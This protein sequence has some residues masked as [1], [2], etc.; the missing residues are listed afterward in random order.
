MLNQLILNDKSSNYLITSTDVNNRYSLVIER[1][2]SEMN[3]TKK[4]IENNPDIKHISL[5]LIDK[6]GKIISSI[7]NEDLLLNNYGL[8]DKSKIYKIG[9][10]IS[11]NQIR[12]VISFTQIS[13]HKNKKLVIINDASRMNMEASSALLKTL[14]EVSS[15]CSFILIC[16]SHK[17]VHETIRSRCQLIK[18]DSYH[19]NKFNNFNEFFFSRH[20]FLKENDQYYDI[21]SLLVN[22]VD[23][24]NGLLDKSH[25]PIDVSA[26][27]YKS[28]I[29]LI[30]EIITS[31]IIYVLKNYISSN[32]NASS[33]KDS[34]KKLLDIYEIIPTIKKNILMNI[35]SKYLLNNLSIELAR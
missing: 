25:D 9:N 24:I 23:Q 8:A 12:E 34:I 28:D 18:I 16:S 4:E 33:S 27:W 19:D 6:A 14:E 32:L 31:Y 29:K 5:P 11:I 30:L 10:E 17:H 22:T 2:C 21:T 20:S 26:T 1:I 3:I 35:N 13:A 7:S 15:N